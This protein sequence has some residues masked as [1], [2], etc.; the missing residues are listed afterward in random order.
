MKVETMNA[1][2][3][4]TVVGMLAAGLLSAATLNVEMNVS[5]GIESKN[6][7]TKCRKVA[8]FVVDRSGSM[9]EA[10]LDNGQSTP[11]EALLESLKLRLDAL[12]DGASVHLIPF[13]S[14][15]KAM[16]SYPS[17]DNRTRRQIVDF[18]KNDAPKGQTL[19]Y[20]AQDL[21]LTE[22][23]RTMQRNP[24]ADVSVYVYTDGLH[25]TPYNYEGDY[26][27][28]SQLRKSRGRGF[29]T[30]P[31][32]VR[33]RQAAFEK[34][35]KKFAD[36]VAKPN[37][38]VE[39]EWLSSSAKPDTSD[40]GTK[41]RIGTVL[42]SQVSSLK[43]PRTEPEQT[44]K[45]NLFLPITDSCWKEV[46][47]KKVSLDFEVDGKRFT[48]VFGL[49]AGSN[50]FKIDWPAL[51]DDKPV[52]AR[53][54]LSRMPGGRKF[55]LKD[56]KPL[57]MAVPAQ[58][59]TSVAI[60]S[61]SVGYIAPV[62]AKISF[63]AKASDGAS[64]KWSI[65]GEKDLSGMSVDWVAKASG[66]V[67][68]K[69]TASKTGLKDAVANGTLEVIPT[70]V[71]IESAVDRHEVGK[72]SA[73]RAK[74]E[75]PCQRYAWTVDGKRV[76]GETGIMKHVF[77]SSGKHQVGVT[78]IYRGGIAKDAER[79]DVAVSAAP[80]VEILSPLAYD[81]DADNAQYQAEKPIELLARAEGDLATATWQFKL[82]D[83]MATVPTEI[84]SGRAAGR[85]TPQKGGFYDVTVTAKGPAGEKSK[86]IQIFVKSSEV[87]VDVVSPAA[88][89]EV[90]TGK[91]IELSAVTKGPVKSI[92]WKIVDKATAKSVQFG[93][94]DVSAVVDGKTA[95]KA[96]LP[97]ELGN[98]SLE[99]QAEPVL[100][101]K[102]L[103]DTI[104][105]SSISIE[106][107]TLA[108]IAYTP[109]TLANN[110]KRV[111]FGRQVQL[112]VT[113]MGA[114]KKVAWFTFDADGKEK[115]LGKDGMSVN[116]DIPVLRGQSECHVDFLAKGLMPDGNWISADQRVTI[117]ACCPCVLVDAG[118]SP[119]IKLPEEKGIP[120]TSYGLKEPMQTAIASPDGCELC[121]VTWDM[122]DKTKYSA[123]V[124]NHPGYAE[125]GTYVISAN[126]KCKTCDRD[127]PID[128][129]KIVVEKQDPVAVLEILEQ[130]SHYG[131]GDKITLS[132]AK[133]KGDIVDYIWELDGQEIAKSRGKKEVV[134][135]LPGSPCEM[136]ARLKLL[137]PEGTESVSEPRIIRVRYGAVGVVILI[138]L[139]LLVVG[140]LAKLLLKNAPAGWKAKVYCCE[141]I[142]LATDEGRRKEQRK[143]DNGDDVRIGK[144]WSLWDK[145]ATIPLKRLAEQ[146]PRIERFFR[147]CNVGATITVAEDDVGRPAISHQALALNSQ[148]RDLNGNAYR[149]YRAAK[150]WPKG[151]EPKF[152]RFVVVETSPAHFYLIL[153]FILVLCVIYAAFLVALRYAI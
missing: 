124:A 56:P 95:I 34:F 110:W 131:I 146:Y 38:E 97:L 29:E 134:V 120:K 151:K 37:L 1:K 2:S 59:R 128:P 152:M 17:L 54:A 64:V 43:N 117:V 20:D 108:Q 9:T 70:G 94:S 150:P 40:W 15:I 119:K 121:D 126:G 102:D 19:L 135:K 125:Y 67:A 96:N 5:H 132:A 25:L 85:Y 99:V 90:E 72:E 13:A 30:N 39:Y 147:L 84:K 36:M 69:A 133:S 127:I 24:G 48:K 28:R 115:E 73:F 22:A 101:D 111:G 114:V 116:V 145:R 123:A 11:N 74:T 65:G 12:P 76:P 86:T 62:G 122:G 129:V 10:T 42:S 53:L 7:G 83:K 142:N 103:A 92:R 61:P 55:D 149:Q 50:S 109:D 45:C 68:Y 100:D 113:A 106:A 49:N 46:E 143:C 82:K 21:A 27:A 35:K 87:R 57:E 6:G 32:Y 153:F 148:V 18:V 140:I 88:N 78:A 98:T 105:P 130:G 93:S 66:R 141:E 71:K 107:R 75:G 136:V 4:F 33:E 139:V 81:G 3:V 14:V 52:T 144:Y 44:M 26:P 51:P 63:V 31:G 23:A 77:E 80:F 91:E 112:A 16:Q 137:G 104:E 118:S 60:E 89:Q 58:G 47:G 79:L 138:L 8:Y 41:P